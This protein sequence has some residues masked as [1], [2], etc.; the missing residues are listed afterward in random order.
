MDILI[1]LAVVALIA[2]IVY[3]AKHHTPAPVADP[4]ATVAVV[5]AGMQGQFDQ[6][7]EDIGNLLAGVPALVSAEVAKLQA[8]LAEAVQRAQ[9]AEAAAADAKAAHEADLAT[10]AARIAAAVNAS[11]E[12]PP[13]TPGPTAP[14]PAV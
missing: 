11:P 14:E 9:A 12:L 13:I 1:G 3:L 6:L 5:T 10:V 2:G 8:D 7:R 4:K